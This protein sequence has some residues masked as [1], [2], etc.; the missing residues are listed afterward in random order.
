RAQR[1]RDAADGLRAAH[2]DAVRRGKGVVRVRVVGE[3]LAH[4]SAADLLVVHALDDADD[5]RGLPV[6][7]AARD[8]PADRVPA[9]EELLGERA[10][11]DDGERR[12]DAFRGIEVA[13]GEQPDAHGAEVAGAPRAGLGVE[14]LVVVHGRL[15]DDGER[16]A[17]AA[18]AER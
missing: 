18:A 11:D 2:D 1:V 6:R 8:L 5:R 13:A 9:R 16:T 10:V 7:V 14:L 4:G 15:A 17:V 12:A 3:G